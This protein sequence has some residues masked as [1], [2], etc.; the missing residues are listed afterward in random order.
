MMDYTL[1]PY[2]TV[3]GAA[4]A[5]EFYGQ[6]FGATE[7]N[8]MVAEDGKRI[9]HAEIALN[10]G[11]IMLGDHFPEFCTHG[12]VTLPTFENPGANSVAL[13][14]KTPA[15]VDDTYKQALDAG[16]RSVQAPENTFWNAR[17]AI[18][19]DPFGHQWMLNAPL[20]AQS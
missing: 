4:K 7:K 18:I 8:R 17:F 14:F 9:M 6:A 1:N 19:C 20:A 16:A 10:G 3:D 15:E 11:V 12:A 13:H 2:L 5:I